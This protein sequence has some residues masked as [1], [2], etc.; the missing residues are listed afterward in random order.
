MPVIT[1]DL[2]GKPF[3][4]GGRGPDTYDC[5][6]LASEIFRR[7]GVDLPEYSICCED[8]SSINAAIDGNRKT[9]VRCE[10]EP[11]VPSMVV[12]RLGSEWCNHTGVYIGHGQFIHTR[13]RI[14]VHI[15]RIDAI[16]WRH[17]I[18]GIYVPEWVKYGN[19]NSSP[20]SV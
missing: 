8:A 3:T 20:E 11:P 13:E 12:M 5:Y 7:Y 17:R 15:D 1:D 10:D 6:G 16:N 18:E 2:I 9:W 19:N 14:G 4:D